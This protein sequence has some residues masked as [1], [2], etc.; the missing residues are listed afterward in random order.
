M[1]R[2]GIA[3]A[4]VG[5]LGLTCALHAQ[6]DPGRLLAEAIR[7]IGVQGRLDQLAAEQLRTRGVLHTARGDVPFVG[8]SIVQLP[9]QFRT[10]MQLEQAGRKNL[11]VH[12]VDGN[13]GW[14]SVDGRTVPLEGPLLAEALETMY[15]HR[16]HRLLPLVRERGFQFSML[17]ADRIGEQPVIGLRVASAGH[18]DIELYF[19]ATSRL[20]VKS[21]RRVYSA[22][23]G[24]EVAQEE[25]Y[26]QYK[27]VGGLRRPTQVSIRHDG[28]PFMDV[29]MLDIKLTGRLPDKVFGK[30]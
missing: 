12:V 27:D 22:A 24:R 4:V 11:V 7:A 5:L 29:E 21:Q 2:M 16:V 30:P 6:D 20:L 10:V 25:F 18:R 17:G 1:P 28:Q 13:K 9:N 14:M 15:A 23:L 8:E 19:D 26:G 3:P